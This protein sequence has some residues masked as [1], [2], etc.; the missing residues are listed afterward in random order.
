[1]KTNSELEREAYIQG[2]VFLAHIYAGWADTYVKLSEMERDVP[3]VPF[4]YEE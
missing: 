2:D 4:D 3:C 1:M